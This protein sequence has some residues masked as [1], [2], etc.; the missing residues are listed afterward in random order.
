[1]QNYVSSFLNFNFRNNNNNKKIDREKDVPYIMRPK[2]N[3]WRNTGESEVIESESHS[4]VANS[5]RHHGL[6][7]PWNSPGQNTEVGSGSLLQGIFPTQGSSPGFLR[8]RQIHYQL[9][10]QGS[11][12][13]LEWVAYP[14][15]SRSSWPRNG[16]GVF[17]TAGRFFT[18]WGTSVTKLLSHVQLWNPMDCSLP[19][20]SVHGIF[21]TRVLEWVA[22]S[23]SRGSSRPRDWTHISC[24]GK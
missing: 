16:T 1:M 18:S 22:I 13:I 6:Y 11:P 4:V 5:L 14:F 23:F 20:S 2:Q 3:F 10:H 8:Y 19:I 24:I 7:S 21:Q 15:S 17:C 9:N 12:G